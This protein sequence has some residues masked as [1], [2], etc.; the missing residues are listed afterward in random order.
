MLAPVERVLR[1][2]PGRS[3]QIQHVEDSLHDLNLVARDHIVSLAEG[4]HD[5]ERRV[6]EPGLRDAQPAEHGL[7][8]SPADEPAYEGTE[9]Q[10]LDACGERADHGADQDEHARSLAGVAI[11]SDPAFRAPS[12]PAPR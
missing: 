1:L 9:E 5:R 3:V 11:Q 4:P 2:L 12:W 6:D 8:E 10:A 7:A